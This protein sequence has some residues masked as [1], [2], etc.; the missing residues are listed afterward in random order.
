MNKI[1]CE[2]LIVELVTVMSA[3]SIDNSDGADAHSI[4]A[5]ELVD[6]LKVSGT[7]AL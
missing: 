6:M 3:H 5:K 1:S 4:K 7:L 2:E